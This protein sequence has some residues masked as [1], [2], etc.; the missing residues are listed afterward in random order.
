MFCF[1]KPVSDLRISIIGLGLIGGSLAKAFRERTGITDI[2]AVD[3]DGSVIE[4][5]LADG[6]ISRGFTQLNSL[7]TDSD[8]IFICTTVKKSVEYMKLLAEKVKPGS[9]ITDVGSTKEEILRVA[10]EHPLKPLFIGG[11]PMA[12]SE[13]EGY[14]SSSSHMFENAYY[15]L[16][17]GRNTPQKAIEAMRSLLSAIGAIPIVMDAFE[18]DLVAGCISHIPHI[19]ASLLVN[20]ARD[21]DTPDE[22]MKLLA[23]GGFRDITR[24]A[25]SNPDLWESI[26]FS[27]KK[28]I[29]QLLAR[30]SDMLAGFSLKLELNDTDWVRSFFSDAREYRNSLSAAPKSLLPPEYSIVVDVVDKPGAIGRL[31]S[32]LGMNGINIKNINVR[33]NREMEGGSITIT[34]P[35]AESAQKAVR[36]LLDNGYAAYARF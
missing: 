31:A 12:G 32:I 2:T 14:A 17:P 30:I 29:R 7:A 25:S 1:D 9:L 6:T 5:A 18:H 34:L 16:T 35:D 33:N 26:V 19:V 20:L 4:K 11:H 27:N 13:Q 24:I 10:E 36:L 15:I 28:Q 22:K 8:I 21:L 23:A 3:S